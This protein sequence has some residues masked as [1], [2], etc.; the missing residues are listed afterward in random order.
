VGNHHLQDGWQDGFPRLQPGRVLSMMAPCR[1]CKAC[2]WARQ[3]MWGQRAVAEWKAT[4]RAGL[5]SWFGTLTFA[6][7]Q[8]FLVTA[9]ARKRLDGQGVNL[10][11]LPP[12]EQFRELH[13]EMGPLVTKYLKRLRAGNRKAGMPAVAFRQFLTVEPHKDWSPHYHLMVHE[14]DLLKPVLKKCLD[15]QWPYGFVQWR[16]VKEGP[17]E[18]TGKFY[19]GEQRAFYVAKYLGKLSIARVRASA[20]YGRME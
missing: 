19:T 11:G 12:Y 20:N 14:S 1:K 4:E 10:E 15:G 13:R 5:R 2:L 6:P 16:L 18:K 9:Q 3:K 8:R 17:D 7:E